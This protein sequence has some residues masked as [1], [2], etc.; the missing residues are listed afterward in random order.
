VFLRGGHKNNLANIEFI[1]WFKR[2]ELHRMASHI[3]RA[4]LTLED[5]AEWVMTDDAH[6]QG[7][8]RVTI[9]LGRPLDELCKVV[10]ESE[11]DSVFRAFIFLRKGFRSSKQEE[12]A[13]DDT[14][15]GTSPD[16]TR[17]NPKDGA[18]TA[19]RSPVIALPQ[20]NI[21]H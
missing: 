17:I 16:L 6:Q 11:L 19:P 13:S 18:P 5:F 8:A 9:R 21:H 1:I 15:D 14:A 4:Q 12:P 2:L 3:P 20:P 10:Q 7:R